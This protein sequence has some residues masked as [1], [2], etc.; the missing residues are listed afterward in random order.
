MFSYFQNFSPTILL[1]E[2]GLDLFDA[3]L[4]IDGDDV[5]FSCIFDILKG[6]FFIKQANM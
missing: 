6:R 2:A 3:L 4:N 5:L 1:T